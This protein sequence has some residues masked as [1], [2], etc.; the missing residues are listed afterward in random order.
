MYL[1][2]GLVTSRRQDGSPQSV[3]SAAQ[4]A[5]GAWK[6]LS[7]NGWSWCS[8]CEDDD[9]ERRKWWSDG[10]NGERL[11]TRKIVQT[12]LWLQ[13]SCDGTPP[14][15]SPSRPMVKWCFKTRLTNTQTSNITY[16][17]KPNRT[18][19][20][21]W[22]SSFRKQPKS[23]EMALWS[24]LCLLKDKGGWAARGIICPLSTAALCLC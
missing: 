1:I 23:R 14:S 19:L 8:L 9:G 10:G 5:R 12:K 20:E 11:G 22:T 7:L 6:G 21:S 15:D 4:G 2:R 13:C 3:C 16:K 17:T 24:A 18:T